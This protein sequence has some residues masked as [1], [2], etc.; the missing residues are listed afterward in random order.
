MIPEEEDELKQLIAEQA[1][2][3]RTG[4]RVWTHSLESV[5]AENASGE[6]FTLGNRVGVDFFGDSWEVQHKRKHAS[7][8][9]KP[10]YL[11]I[12]KELRHWNHGH[13]K[14]FFT[15]RG[16]P[17]RTSL[18][19]F[20]AGA[21]QFFEIPCSFKASSWIHGKGY[22]GNHAKRLTTMSSD[23]NSTL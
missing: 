13:I 11:R 2:D 18:C 7:P 21:G 1:R 22:C 19:Q 5:I 10:W 9:R 15:W 4:N 23:V 3:L 12:P 17:N 16:P 14:P 20:M 6:E 8:R